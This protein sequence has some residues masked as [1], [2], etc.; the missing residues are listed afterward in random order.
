VSL[1][2]AAEIEAG[3]VRT[4]VPREVAH[5]R[6][7]ELTAAPDSTPIPLAT[8][9]DWPVRLTLPWSC[10]ISDNRRHGVIDGKLLLTSDYRRSKGLIRDHARNRL[11]RVQPATIP[12][13]LTAR[14]WVPDDTR[15]HDVAN[16][17]KATHDALE[18]VV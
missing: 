4:G 7:L 3:L 18:G 1:L 13:S 17:A 5:R 12:L 2:T 6:A 14:V 9:I 11:G 10:L 15:A 8:G 16:F